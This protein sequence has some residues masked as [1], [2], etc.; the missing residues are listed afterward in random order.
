[1]PISRQDAAVDLLDLLAQL[2]FVDA[3]QLACG[4][5]RTSPPTRTVSTEWPVEP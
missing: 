3:G 1:M 5:S 4:R 2:A